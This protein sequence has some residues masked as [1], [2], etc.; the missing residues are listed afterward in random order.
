MGDGDP[1]RIAY[2]EPGPASEAGVSRVRDRS[3]PGTAP[4]RRGGRSRNAPISLA[5]IANR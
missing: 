4:E 3:L 1:R 5:S 2:E